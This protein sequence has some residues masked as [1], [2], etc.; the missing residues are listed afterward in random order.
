MNTPSRLLAAGAIALAVAAAPTA[1][2]ADAPPAAGFEAPPVTNDNQIW[3]RVQPLSHEPGINVPGKPNKGKDI[4]KNMAHFEHTDTG[5]MVWNSLTVTGLFS[6]KN[7]PAIN[8][9]GATEFYTTYRGDVSATGF[10]QPPITMPG[11]SDLMF[12]FGGDLN[13]KD[14]QY[15]PRRKFLLLGPIFYFDLPGSVTFAVHFAKE[16]GHQGFTNRTENYNPTWNTELSWTE[17][18]DPLV[19]IPVRWEGVFNVT[20]PK[21]TDTLGV[22]TKTEFYTYSSLIL[23]V[24]EVFHSKPHVFDAFVGVQYWYNKFGNPTKNDGGAIELTP[25]I[26]VGVHF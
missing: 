2:A 11:V 18:L 6:D 3:F 22:H 14:T 13:W 5:G 7:D 24:G 10:G 16:W 26:G 9:S 19:H 4:V 12:E 20:G 1:H 17:Y 23:D 21:G 8:G 25:Y 15:A